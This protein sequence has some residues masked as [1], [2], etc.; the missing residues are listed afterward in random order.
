MIKFQLEP[1]Y[2]N[3][4]KKEMMWKA[5][6]GMVNE[7][8]TQNWFRYFKESDISLENKP[9]S[10]GPSFVENEALLETKFLVHCW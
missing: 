9:R 2:T 7:C 1:F 5:G 6:L 4:G 3:C 10:G 8:V